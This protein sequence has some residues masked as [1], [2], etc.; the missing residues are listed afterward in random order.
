MLQV[1]SEVFDLKPTRCQRTRRSSLAKPP[2]RKERK[3][4]RRYDGNR[5]HCGSVPRFTSSRRLT[6]IRTTGEIPILSDSVEMA[7]SIALV[8]SVRALD[9]PDLA[10]IV[11]RRDSRFTSIGKCWLF[12]KPDTFV[13]ILAGET[14]RA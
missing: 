9:G 7:E 6:I 5:K 1:S 13:Q 4:R 11:N 14:S 3:P 12:S 2:S 8:A 10:V